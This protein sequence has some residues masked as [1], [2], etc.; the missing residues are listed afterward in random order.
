MAYLAAPL[1]TSFCEVARNSV[2]VPSGGAVVLM[3]ALANAF[4]L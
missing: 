2:Y 1:D 3:P 4:L